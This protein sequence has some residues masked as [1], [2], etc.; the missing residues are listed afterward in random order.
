MIRVLIISV[1]SVIIIQLLKQYRS[2]YTIVFKLAA[3]ITIGFLVINEFKDSSAVFSFLSDFDGASVSYL[4]IILK[5]LGIVIVTQLASNICRD[6]GEETLSTLTELVGK[7]FILITCLPII[8]ALY[9]LVKG[10]LEL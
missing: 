9:N 4:P 7:L 10:Y 5:T 1:I 8:E 3:I 2:E 6:S